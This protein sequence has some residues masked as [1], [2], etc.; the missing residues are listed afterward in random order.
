MIRNFTA[1][2]TA[3]ARKVCDTV[4][5]RKEIQ[6]PGWQWHTIQQHWKKLRRASESTSGWVKTKT[7]DY[8]LHSE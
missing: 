8:L 1:V 2:I 7:V 4:P 5:N 6:G 3:A